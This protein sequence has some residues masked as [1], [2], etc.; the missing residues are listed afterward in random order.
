M[1]RNSYFYILFYKKLSSRKTYY[2]SAFRCQATITVLAEVNNTAK[3]KKRNKTKRF[4]RYLLPSAVFTNTRSL[5]KLNRSSNIK[6]NSKRSF[7]VWLYQQIKYL[8]GVIVYFLR[9]FN[10]LQQLKIAL[11]V[12]KFCF[13]F[14]YTRALE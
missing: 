14:K 6:Y 8:I 11:Y 2:K 13:Q 1:T 7:K 12:V 4:I 3:K 5:K 9:Q 10:F